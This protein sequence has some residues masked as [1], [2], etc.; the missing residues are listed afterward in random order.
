M[1]AN[2]KLLTCVLVVAAAPTAQDRLR[3]MPGYEQYTRM[4]SQLQTAFVSGAAQGV[5]WADDSAS[6]RYTL[7]DN[8]IDSTSRDEGQGGRI[9]RPR[10]PGRGRRGTRSTARRSAARGGLEQARDACAR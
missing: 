4:Q 9:A 1:R 7:G 10:R 5:Q 8:R 6:F 3:L 2:S